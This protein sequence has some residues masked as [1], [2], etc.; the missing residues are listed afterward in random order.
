MRSR[1]RFLASIVV[2]LVMSGTDLRAERPNIV[3][4]I[5]E[6][7]SS[8]F[9]F[10]GEE[11]VSTPH[12]DRLAAEGVVFR[13]AYVTSPVCSTS[14][15]ALITG[16]YQTSIGAH[17]HRSSRGEVVRRLPEGVETIPE[18]FRR[19]G[20]YTCNLA[21]SGRRPERFDR[22]GKEDYNFVYERSDLYD[23]ADWSGRKDGQ[24]FFAQVQLHGGKLRHGRGWKELVTSSIDESVS[25]AEV[26]LPPYYPDHPVFRK[27]WA[28]YLDTVQYT[29][30]EVGL[31]MA[32]LERE[33]LL[34]NTV[35]VFLTDHG[36]SQARGK[37]FVYEEGA[38]VPLVVWS[39]RG[40]P[41]ESVRNDLVAHI[42]VA[43]TTLELAGIDLPEGLQGRPLFGPRA[44]GREFVVSA[45]DR[46]DETVDRIRGLTQGRYKYIR[47]YYPQ[48]PYLQPC[49]YKDKKPFMGPLR[50]L[51]AA[52]KLT[53]AQALHLAETRPEE[54]LYDLE[55]DPFEVRNLA[56]DPAHRERLRALRGQLENWVIESDDRGRFPESDAMYDSDM[57]VYI[58]GQ[59]RR[60][61]LEG[62]ARIEANIALMKRWRAEGK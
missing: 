44:R 19:A 1:V 31:I 45:R 25:P 37:Q 10:Q 47:N 35:L 32:R 23:G 12:V 20:Y 54:E 49:A 6:D 14:R 9:A 13:R 24:P 18:L 41:Q 50:E 27:D 38:R 39:R 40:L 48:R 58:E 61:N 57:R 52:G 34:D 26:E 3:W 2:C 16:R 11:L 5:V 42:D 43:A 62:A 59:K 60:K 4:I 56:A 46:C 17:H 36:I 28:A 22:P 51:Y 33:A 8:H 29:D 21:F 53:P 15:S 30:I 7:M 55:S